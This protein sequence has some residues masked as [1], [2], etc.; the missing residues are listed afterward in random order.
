MEE[1][2][3]PSINV[4]IDALNQATLNYGTRMNQYMPGKRI[5]D[6][7]IQM[8]ES[9]CYQRASTI[10]NDSTQTTTYNFIPRKIED[11][12]SVTNAISLTV[13]NSILNSIY[14]NGITVG[15]IL[16]EQVDLA[17]D[18][19]RAK[20][21]SK[22]NAKSVKDKLIDSFKNRKK[23]I[24]DHKEKIKNA[25]KI[26]GIVAGI[27]TIVAGA[28]ALAN[29]VDAK[30]NTNSP[31]EGTTITQQVTGAPEGYMTPEQEEEREKALQEA[32]E[33]YE[34]EHNP[35]YGLA[36]QYSNEMNEMSGGKSH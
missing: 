35:L 20:Q 33:T 21:F 25:L 22:E 28:S 4:N 5:F 32:N 18:P 34:K 23:D 30:L 17:N 10:E 13:A 2:I 16:K 14:E 6:I 26:G 31:Y 12:Q 7:V 19:K 24:S 15:Q 29:V 1:R 11:G 9:N 3:M 36:E 8:N 27:V